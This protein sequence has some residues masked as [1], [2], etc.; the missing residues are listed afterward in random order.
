MNFDNKKVYEVKEDGSNLW[1]YD[2]DDKIICE[3]FTKSPDE[4]EAEFES[5]GYKKL[6]IRYEGKDLF[7]FEQN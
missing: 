7:Y 1:L 4:T 6:P 2:S 3:V 5:A